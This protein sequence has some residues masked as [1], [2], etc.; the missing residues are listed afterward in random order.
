MTS[1]CTQTITRYL[2][3]WCLSHQQLECLVQPAQQAFP[4]NWMAAE[5]AM[6]SAALRVGE[7]C[8]AAL[9]TMREQ[10]R[11]M[12]QVAACT[13]EL[14]C[15]GVQCI[16]A[17]TVI[18]PGIAGMS[19][20]LATACGGPQTMMLKHGKANCRLCAAGLQFGQAGGACLGDT[21]RR[22]SNG[23]QIPGPLYC[24]CWA[25]GISWSHSC[26]TYAGTRGRPAQSCCRKWSG[27]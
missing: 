7:A 27:S 24:R 10:L 18:S 9:A 23:A 20:C 22:T 15:G 13:T 14:P 25:R 5:R 4:G 6:A 12:M 26:S 2:T 17:R 8:V 11:N 16:A 1:H 21:Q 19:S 3:S